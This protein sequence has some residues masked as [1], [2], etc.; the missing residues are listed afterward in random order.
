MDKAKEIRQRE[1]D[2]LELEKLRLQVQCDDYAAGLKNKARDEDYDERTEYRRD[3][4]RS[5][6]DNRGM[7]SDTYKRVKDAYQSNSDGKADDTSL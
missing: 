3:Y 5:D 7:G 4:G 1:A 2:K 6:N